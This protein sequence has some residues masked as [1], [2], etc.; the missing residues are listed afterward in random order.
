MKLITVKSESQYPVKIGV[1]WRAEIDSILSIHNKILILAP[2]SII[3]R[4]KLKESSG[5]LLFQTPEGESQKSLQT[6]DKVWSKCAAEGVSR[7][8]AIIGIGGGAT[9]DLAGFAASAWL[10]GVAWYAFPTTLAGMVDAAIGGKTGINSKAGKNLIGSFYSPTQV[11]IDLV[12][13]DT[14]PSRDVSAGMTEVI[15]CGFIVD[16][17]IINLAQDDE[18]DFEQLIYRSIKVK[19]DV[20]SRDFKESKLREILNYGHTLG[21]AIEKNSGYKLRHGEAVSIGMVFAAELSKELAGLSEDVVLLHRELLK[22]F[23][24]PTNY[25]RSKFKQLL[26]L[27]SN[28]KKVRNSKLRFIGIKKIG[29]P[30]W[31][32]DVSPKILSKVYERIAK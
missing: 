2:K 30:V 32:D 5:V 18:M 22:S 17:K 24:L 27:L 14:L 19:A 28:D 12:F 9:T 31:F 10:R 7:A 16:N 21:H 3:T 23:D 25:P 20:V 11:L 1:N 8:D 6:V 13:L 26:A 4:Y 15:K 29:K